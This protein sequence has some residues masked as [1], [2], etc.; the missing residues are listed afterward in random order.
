MSLYTT[1]CH[2]IH[3]CSI[4][5]VCELMFI[6]EHLPYFQLVQYISF[7]QLLYTGKHPVINNV[8]TDK[9]IIKLMYQ[10]VIIQQSGK[11]ALIAG[12]E[13]DNT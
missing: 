7:M 1:H 5:R 6:M 11:E 4:G 2:A 12:T 10:T 8:K 9:Y 3:A 13:M